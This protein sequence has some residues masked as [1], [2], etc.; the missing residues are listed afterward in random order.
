[1]NDNLRNLNHEAQEAMDGSPAAV[2]DAAG[3]INIRFQCGPVKE[4]G[5]NG[6][7]IENVLELLIERL[8][9]FQKGP[10]SCRENAVAITKMEEA[11][12]WLE[13]R[14]QARVKAGVEGT[15]QAH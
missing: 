7:S 10:F 3:Y 1:M 13:K 5:V 14:T 15:N 12:M 11:A 9:G 2:R 8:R 6:T 4:V